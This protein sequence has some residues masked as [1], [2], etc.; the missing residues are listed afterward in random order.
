M[1]QIEKNPDERYRKPTTLNREEL[2]YTFTRT[3]SSMVILF[4]VGG[5]CASVAFMTVQQLRK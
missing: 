5:V 3:L 1:P 2:E 4:A